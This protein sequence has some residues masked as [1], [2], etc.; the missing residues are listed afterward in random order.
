MVLYYFKHGI[1][2]S[3]VPNMQS[4][5]FLQSDGHM[6]TSGWALLYPGNS[7]HWLAKIISIYSLGSPSLDSE[8]TGLPGI[9]GCMGEEWGPGQNQDFINNVERKETMGVRQVIKIVFSLSS[10][11]ECSLVV[12]TEKNKVKVTEQYKR[13]NRVLHRVHIEHEEFP[14]LN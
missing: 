12:K 7:I 9:M 10:F 2:I 1:Q 11:M 13:I 6:L 14:F 3:V 4:N 8:A 5:S